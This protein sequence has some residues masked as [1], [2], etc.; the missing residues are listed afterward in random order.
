MGFNPLES[1]QRDIS[2][3]R[4][5]LGAPGLYW[6]TTTP[7]NLPSIRQ[8]GLV[9]AEPEFA[10]FGALIPRERTIGRVYLTEGKHGAIG[11]A[12]EAVRQYKASPGNY[13][14][15]GV[16]IPRGARVRSDVVAGPFE[17]IYI[18]KPI[19]ADLIILEGEFF[20]PKGGFELESDET[21]ALTRAIRLRPF[22]KP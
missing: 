14:L 7:V 6:H 15:L 12:G 4:R 22:H 2:R 5:A 16:N 8:R 10:G 13:I 20:L 17:A 1:I 21:D 11:M 18:A 19:P 3:V 9:P